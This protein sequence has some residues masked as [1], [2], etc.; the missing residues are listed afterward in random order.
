M[1][2]FSLFSSHKSDPAPTPAISVDDESLIGITSSPDPTR[3]K[4]K[5]IKAYKRFICVFINYEEAI[6]YEGNKII[7]LKDSTV[8]EIKSLKEI[9][10]HF[11]EKGKVIAR[12]EPTEEGWK[13]AT[14]YARIK[15]AGLTH[16]SF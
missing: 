6:N 10:P 2:V 7:V 1:G 9:D 16:Q 13:D 4:I 15:S 5:K 8:D 11:W 3:F 12:F 14:L